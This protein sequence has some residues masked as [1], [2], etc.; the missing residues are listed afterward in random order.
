VEEEQ[1]DDG[2]D[3]D[4]NNNNNNNVREN[5]VKCMCLCR[6]LKFYSL[7]LSATIDVL[8]TYKELRSVSAA[9]E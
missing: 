5:F 3:E 7:F 2:N 4:G 9:T 8:K 1:E 6:S